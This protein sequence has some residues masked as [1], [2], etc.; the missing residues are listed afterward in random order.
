MKIPGIGEILHDESGRR[1]RVA[2]VQLGEGVEEA[3]PE[4]MTL[5]IDLDPLPERPPVPPAF[6]EAVRE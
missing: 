5:Y 4:R 1:Y 6:E 3:R 2:G